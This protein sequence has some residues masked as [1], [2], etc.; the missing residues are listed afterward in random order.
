MFRGDARG[1]S[2]I[3]GAILIFAIV[4]GLI[5]INQ[6]FLVPPDNADIEA[7]H[8]KAVT[9]DMV[10]LRG[11]IIRAAS[12]NNQKSASVQ[13]GTDYP[14]RFLSLNPPPAAGSLE[15]TTPEQN[16]TIEIDNNTS[17]LRRLCGLDENGDDVSTTFLT[18][19]TNY[20]EYR[21]ELPTTVENTVVHRDGETKNLLDSGQVVVKGNH[22]RVIRLVGDYRETG[23]K[24]TEV[25]LLPSNTGRINVDEGN[26]SDNITIP[27]NLDTKDWKSLL[28]T[29]DHEVVDGEDGKQVV[30]KLDNSPEN[31]VI[32]CTTVGIDEQPEVE[33][34]QLNLDEPPRSGVRINPASDAL[35]LVDTTEGT[36]QEPDLNMTFEN[37][38]N[39]TLTLQQARIPFLIEEGGGG[40]GEVD[41]FTDFD[42]GSALNLV[43]GDPLK[44]VEEQREIEW[45][46]GSKNK[47]HL[48]GFKGPQ[49]TGLAI[50][51][52][53]QNKE[54]ETME[55]IYFVSL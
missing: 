49:N 48:D 45:G 32:E 54:G 31:Y 12:S 55:F 44:P 52:Q 25:D 50:E 28:K 11:E 6:V 5:G 51:L 26:I 30:I 27:T 19:Q 20:N 15:T 17:N 34:P 1:Q 9:D 47:I 16:I 10:E 4:V 43:V 39:S 53:L 14:S 37:D 46:E 3:I 21:G 29:E 13:L 22:I 36:G 42:D 2:E 23:L 7:Q 33:P 41:F 40:A 35:V 8:D 24:T 18:Y 38:M